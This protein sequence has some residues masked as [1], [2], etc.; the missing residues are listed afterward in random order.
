MKSQTPVDDDLDQQEGGWEFDADVAAEF[1]THVRKSIPHYTAIQTQVAKL[2]D[3]FLTGDGT[4]PEYVYDLGCATGETISRLIDHHDGTA[5]IKYVGI[6]E[7]PAMLEQA[8]AKI[9]SQADYRLVNNDISVDPAFPDATLVISLFTLSFLPEQDRQRVVNAIYDDL[10]RGGA[11][12]FCE[13]TRAGNALFQDIWTEHY[14][15]F[16]R[17]QGLSDDQILGKARSLRGQLRPLT[18]A[19]YDEMLTTAGFDA[20]DIGVFFKWHQWTGFIARKA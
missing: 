17:S 10:H 16:K 3:W 20:D 7:Q 11:F 2:S 6:D 1:D 15:D 12:V 19:A 18:R 4:T 9:P 8:D 5:A 14:W 13:K